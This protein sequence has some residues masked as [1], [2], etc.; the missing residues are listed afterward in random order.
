MAIDLGSEST[1]DYGLET[2]EA[3]LTAEQMEMLNEMMVQ[4]VGTDIGTGLEGL[5]YISL[6]I[7]VLYIIFFIA[8]AI[9]LYKLSKKLGDKHSWLAFVPIIQLYTFIKTAGYSFWKG[10]LLLILYSILAMIGA[11][12]FMLVFSSVVTSVM[13]SSGNIAT[14]VITTMIM[15]FITG[16]LMTVAAS[17]FLYLGMARRA[18]QSNGTAVLM[19]FFPW[20]MLWIVANRIQSGVQE[21]STADEV[22]ID[23]G[24]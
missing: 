21:T 17:L 23:T 5:G 11:I 7:N 8:S 4:S 18:G 2:W 24:M 20:C 19:A 13:M 14:M 22:V 6:G 1:L 16:M 15:S 3:E 12:I 10:F 9:G